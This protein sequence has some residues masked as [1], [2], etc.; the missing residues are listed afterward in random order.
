MPGRMS[1]RGVN[2]RE[3]ESEAFDR[4]VEEHRRAKRRMRSDSPKLCMRLPVR[5]GP[6]LSS[7]EGARGCRRRGACIRSDALA[8]PY[9]ARARER[10]L[11]E[12][13]RP[14]WRRGLHAPRLRGFPSQPPSRQGGHAGMPQ[15]RRYGRVCAEI[16]GDIC[17]GGDQKHHGC[18]YGGDVLR[19]AAAYCSNCAAEADKDIPLE[20][21]VI[22]RT[23]NCNYRGIASPLREQS[24][25]AS[26]HKE[27]DR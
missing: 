22:T 26:L 8:G 10:A 14:A 20:E 3:R 17:S 13:R 25:R 11:P 15:V 6:G 18:R 2:D 4:G 24:S 5:G 27:D 7:A 19:A 9:E 1:G 16:R 23:G 21:I 12:R